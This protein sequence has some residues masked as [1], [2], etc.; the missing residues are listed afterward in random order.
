M[1]LLMTKAVLIHETGGPE[2]LSLDEIAIAAPGAG[3][4]VLRHTVLGLN[5]IDIGMREGHYPFVKVPMASPV[6]M[7]LIA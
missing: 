6:R 1:G 3:E 4:V 2:V 5:Y 7:L